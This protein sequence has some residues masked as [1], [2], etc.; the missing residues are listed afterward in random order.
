MSTLP[1]QLIA[2]H[3]SSV[4]AMLAFQNTAF[5]GFERLI[6]LN[7]RVTRAVL[8]EVA[9]KSSE[10]AELQDPQQAFAFVSTAVQPSPEKAIAY[11]KHVYDIM[12][13]VQAQ[14]AKLTETQV[15]EVQKQLAEA[16][17][18]LAKNAPAGSESAVA[19][20]KSVL[21][22]ATSAYD[23]LSKAAKQAAVVTESNIAAA[24]NATFEA[25]EA[26][27]PAARPQQPRRSA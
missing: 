7:L 8:D 15:A 10:A 25:A 16:V 14:V 17:D 24:T 3:K 22:N 1:A 6:D 13:G 4:D 26:A 18:A 12:T 19:L 23:S 5:A 20:T 9:Q 27:K 21:A 2:S 11:S